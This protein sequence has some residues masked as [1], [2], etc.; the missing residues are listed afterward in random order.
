MA[1]LCGQPVATVGAGRTDAG[2]HAEH[3]VVHADVPGDWALL[4]DPSAARH[5]LDARC[6]AAITVWRVR[7]VPG[8]FDARFSATQRRYRYRLC[9]A[10]ALSPLRRHT[11]WHVGPPA[12]DI[13]A[14]EAAGAHVVGEHDFTSFCRRRGTQ[15]LWRRVD[16]LRVRRRRRGLVDVDVDG[17]A[18]CHQMVRSIVGSLLRVGRGH[19][20][21]TWMAEVRDAED[22]AVAGAVAPPHALVLLAVRFGPRARPPA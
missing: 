19:R 11:V 8:S 2:V 18:F 12:L 9:D 6:G 1:T 7:R 21:P 5:A 10:A 22:R 17:A 15:H 14:M 16:R 13:D 3:Q 20:P 4:A